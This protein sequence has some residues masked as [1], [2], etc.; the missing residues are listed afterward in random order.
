MMVSAVLL[1][2][3]LFGFG[4]CVGFAEKRLPMLFGPAVYVFAFWSWSCYG[5]PLPFAAALKDYVACRQM[6]ENN[7]E[8]RLDAFSHLYLAFIVMAA[9]ASTG[10]Y[11]FVWDILTPATAALNLASHAAMLVSMF[12]AEAFSVVKSRNA[13]GYDSQENEEDA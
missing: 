2:L 6:L 5:L 9:V 12:V 8:H 3:S 11:L 10:L 4:L 1:V 13:S 7:E